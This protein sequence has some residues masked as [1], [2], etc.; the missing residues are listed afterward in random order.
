MTCNVQTLTKSFVVAAALA[1]G[2][3]GLAHADEGG[4]LDGPSEAQ[5]QAAASEGPAWHPQQSVYDESPSVWR[6]SNPNGLSMREMQ[7]MW[8]TWAGQFRL[9]QPVFSSASVDD[10]FKQSHPNGL[11][12]REFQ[13]MSSDAAAWQLPM[14]PSTSPLASTN[15][16]SVA[17]SAT[18]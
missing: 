11:S 5:L 17:T 16:A 3:S 6:Q 2:V 4:A 7:S 14:R 9:S 12:A 1:A 18:N 8:G 13:A 10:S 15:R